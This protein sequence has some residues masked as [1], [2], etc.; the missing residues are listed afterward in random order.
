MIGILN[1]NT[2]YAIMIYNVFIITFIR[3]MQMYIMKIFIIKFCSVLSELYIYYGF[4]I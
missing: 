3:W 1:K 4:G 2:C